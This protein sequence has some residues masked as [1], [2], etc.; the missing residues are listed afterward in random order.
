MSPRYTPEAEEIIAALVDAGY[1]AYYV[2]GC[3]RDRLRGVASAD[4]DIATSASL[5]N[6]RSVFA[7]AKT[8]GEAFSVALVKGIEVAS[9]RRDGPYS[10]FRHPDYVELVGTVEED[11]ARRDFTINAIAEDRAGML[12][13]PHDGQRD[14]AAR[15]IRFVGDPRVRLN[16]DPIRALRACRFAGLIGGTIEAASAAAIM[17]GCALLARVPRERVQLELNKILML[18]QRLQALDLVRMLNLLPHVMPRMARAVGVPQEGHHGEDCWTH[19]TAAV[20]AVAKPDLDLRL[21]TFLHDIAKP[22]T[23]TRDASGFDHFYRHEIEGVELVEEELHELRYSTATIEYVKEAV[24][25]HM[26]KLMFAPEM[27]DATVRRLMSSLR[28]MP[29]RD[30][31]RLQVADMHG[32]L[33]KPYTDVELRAHM[34][35]ALQRI[36]T[37]ERAAHALKITDLAING[38]DVMHEL[39]LPAG[40]LV[41]DI[42][43]HCFEAVLHDPTLNTRDTLLNIVRAHGSSKA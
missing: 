6:I 5:E 34:R 30:L 32:N 1:A 10:D 3:V 18:P 36:R 2:G 14:L 9:F 31:L 11:L 13:D 15:I 4:I 24:R 7:A 26:T 17:D 39:G 40:P 20:Q 8:V 42:L 23:R 16:E 43:R 29:V 35:H 27:K 41:G 25:H 21:A 22:G 12:V 33:K 38:T 19:A 37:I 28:L